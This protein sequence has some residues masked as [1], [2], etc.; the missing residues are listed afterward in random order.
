MSS[1]SN[2][3]TG[4]ESREAIRKVISKAGSDPDFRRKAL[5]DANGAVMDLT[6]KALPEGYKLQFVDNAGADQTIVL[7]DDGALTDELDQVAGGIYMKIDGSDGVSN[8]AAATNDD[9][10]FSSRPRRG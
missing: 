7:P 4:Q 8:V 2:E 6:G 1:D 10:S 3:W 9:F 5:S